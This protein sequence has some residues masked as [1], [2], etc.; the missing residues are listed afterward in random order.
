ME[1]E[2]SYIVIEGVRY[3]AVK[4][5]YDT[6]RTCKDCAFYCLG[7]CTLPN[8]AGLFVN[9]NGDYFFVSRG[10]FWVNTQQRP[11][12]QSEKELD[13]D[14]PIAIASDKVKIVGQGSQEPDEKVAAQQRLTERSEKDADHD[15][16]IA[17]KIKAPGQPFESVASRTV[18]TGQYAEFIAD[19]VTR[20]GAI[21]KRDYYSFPNGVEAED[22]CRYLP[23]NLGNVVKYVC[24]AGRKDPKKKALDLQKAMDYLDN[25][26]K[27]MEEEDD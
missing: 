19:K 16:P 12:E 20:A 21:G 2:E 3:D 11:S 18:H 4:F 17:F 23:F 6:T 5:E 10:G 9:C 14:N 24:R 1:K 8:I 27:R 15:E 25:E 26:I 13:L 22:I 7:E